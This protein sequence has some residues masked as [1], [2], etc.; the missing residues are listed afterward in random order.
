MHL[1]KLSRSLLSTAAIVTIFTAAMP[2]AHADTVYDNLVSGTDGADPLLSY[3]PLANSFTTGASAQYLTSVSALLQ[4]GSNGVVGDLGLSLHADSGNAPGSTLVSLGTLSSS[5]VSSAGFAAYAFAPVTTFV[6][7]GNTRY[8]IEIVALTP[9]AIEWAWST[10][11]AAQGVAG[12][13][14]HSAILGTNDNASFGAYQMAVNVASVPEPDS[15]ALLLAGLGGVG[16]V[17]ARRRKAN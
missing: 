11:L 8:W 5:Q 15:V 4:N 16:M 9:N 3:G 6:L 1:S 2:S 14:S 12:E 13:Y 17:T 10:D 7:A